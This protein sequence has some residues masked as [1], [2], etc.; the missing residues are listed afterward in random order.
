MQVTKQEVHVLTEPRLCVAY[1]GNL[2]GR[3]GI[4]NCELSFSNVINTKLC[5][6]FESIS[7]L[8]LGLPNDAVRARRTT[9]TWRS[10][11][12]TKHYRK[13]F[14][15]FKWL[16]GGHFM[17][18]PSSMVYQAGLRWIPKT[19]TILTQTLSGFKT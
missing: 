10:C 14:T 12:V 16:P 1:C 13:G 11:R 4:P 9:A 17:R 19:A 5:R 6:P 18:V 3:H 8:Q 7:N 2:Y 15:W